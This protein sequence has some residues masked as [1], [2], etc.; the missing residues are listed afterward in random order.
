[1]KSAITLG[2]LAALLCVQPAAL[3]GQQADFGT[4]LFKREAWTVRLDASADPDGTTIE[5]VGTTLRLE[6]QRCPVDCGRSRATSVCAW[7]RG[8]RHSSSGSRSS[9]PVAGDSTLACRFL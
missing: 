7:T 8:A 6:S 5:T 3:H 2:A 1:M 9:H 4:E